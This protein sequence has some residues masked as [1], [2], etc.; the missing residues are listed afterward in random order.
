M[1]QLL[2]AAGH[3]NLEFTL[4][5]DAPNKSYALAVQDQ[6][7]HVGITVKLAEIPSATFYGGDQTKD[8]P[9]LFTSANLVGWAGRAVPSQFVAPM[10]TSKGVWNGSKYANP[11]LDGALVAY[12]AAKDDGTRKQQAEII[13]KAL[14]NDV[15]VILTVWNGSVR[16]YNKTKFAG[17]KA[18]PSSYVD[19]STV[20]Q[21]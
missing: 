1:K 2:A 14:H 12:D 19:F 21:V 8:T 10:V 4:S 20:S 13:A 17:I 5:F 9:W 15:P 18:H 16:A 6:L 7:K 3:K 11:A